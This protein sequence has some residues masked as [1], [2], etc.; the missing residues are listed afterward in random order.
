MIKEY[1]ESMIDSGVSI[2]IGGG[3][4]ITPTYFMLSYQAR[5]DYQNR[6]SYV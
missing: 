2:A 1:T 3:M 4:E 6:A 5:P